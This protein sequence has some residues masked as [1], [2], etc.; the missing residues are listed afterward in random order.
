MA[1]EALNNVARH[2]QAGR[3][4]LRCEFTPAQTALEVGDDGVGFAVPKSPA[5]FAPGNHFG[6]LG[7]YERAELIG[8]TLNI[9][10]AAGQG[11]RITVVMP[12]EKGRA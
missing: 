4:W 8:A 11:T 9:E 7:L 3:A 12:V 1:Q 6:L 5:E 10:S 2:A